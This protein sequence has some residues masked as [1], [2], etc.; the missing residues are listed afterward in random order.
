[1]YLSPDADE[2]RRIFM[3]HGLSRQNDAERMKKGQPVQK[4]VF[5]L[6]FIKWK[7]A[8]SALALSLI[9]CI[10][11]YEQ[12]GLYFLQLMKWGVLQYCVLRP[13]YVNET[14]LGITLSD[15]YQGP[16]SSQWFSITWAYIVNPLGVWG[17]GMSMYATSKLATLH[18]LIVIFRSSSLCHC[19]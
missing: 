16:P 2:Q 4:W 19:R 3:K 6:G 11:Y 13:L 17:G 15:L 12:D 8:V 14:F 10:S 1:M 7:P 9:V 5:P 18:R